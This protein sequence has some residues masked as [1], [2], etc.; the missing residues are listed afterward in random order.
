[1]LP[2]LTH[3][4]VLLNRKEYDPDRQPYSEHHE[5]LDSRLAAGGF[6]RARGSSE[7]KLE[8]RLSV[9]RSSVL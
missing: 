8:D 6:E 3:T 1:M 4:G 2:F 7:D 9:S 5:R